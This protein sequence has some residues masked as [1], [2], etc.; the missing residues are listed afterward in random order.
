MRA[1]HVLGNGRVPVRH[2][3]AGVARNATALVQDLDRGVGDARL[4]LLA[5]QARRHRVV[6]IG[7]LDIGKPGLQQKGGVERGAERIRKL[8]Q[9]YKRQR[10]HR[11]IARQEIRIVLEQ[12]LRRYR[13]IRISEGSPTPWTSRGV[14]ALK[15]LP[16]AW[17]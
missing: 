6:M 14:W 8:E 11:R 4:E 2:G 9:H 17:D 3:R 16:L 13:N 15:A 7:D 5:D 1:R 10:D 12:F